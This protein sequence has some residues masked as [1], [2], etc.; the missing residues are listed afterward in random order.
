MGYKTAEPI[1]GLF[2]AVYTFVQCCPFLHSPVP[3]MS[4]VDIYLIYS[5]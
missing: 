3:L 4:L 1:T 2:T 5:A